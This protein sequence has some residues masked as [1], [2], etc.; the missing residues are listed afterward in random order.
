MPLRYHPIDGGIGNGLLE[1]EPLHLRVAPRPALATHFGEGERNDHCDVPALTS[2][3]EASLE[4]FELCSGPGQDI[5]DQ[6]VADVLEAVYSGPYGAGAY[7]HVDVA[8]YEAIK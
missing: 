8:F 2:T 5:Y 6:A 7:E 4:L 1:P 3:I